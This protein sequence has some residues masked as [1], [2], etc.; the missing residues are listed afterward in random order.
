MTLTD[1]LLAGVITTAIAGAAF[2]TFHSSTDESA[3]KSVAAWNS[4][5]GQA[6][7]TDAS[8]QW[9]FFGGVLQ[10]KRN[11]TTT[12]I[13]PD[14]ALDV[15]TMYS[16][17]N[18]IQ[19]GALPSGFQ[20]SPP[21]GLGAAK[22]V[23]RNQRGMLS[24]VVLTETADVPMVQSSA[25]QSAPQAQAAQGYLTA[26]LSNGTF[27]AQKTTLSGAL[28]DYGITSTPASSTFFPAWY[29]FYRPPVTYPPLNL[30]VGGNYNVTVPNGAHSVTLTLAGAPG[31]IPTIGA[32]LYPLINADNLA[33]WETST[34]EPYPFEYLRW[35]GA[36]ETVPL[37]KAPTSGT[38]N[39]LKSFSF[40][41]SYL[42]FG[43]YTVSC[44]GAFACTRSDGYAV[45]ATNATSSCGTSA[46]S[47]SFNFNDPLYG[48]ANSVSGQFPAAG[49][50][51]TGTVFSSQ[52]QSTSNWSGSTSTVGA[53]TN[54]QSPASVKSIIFPGPYGGDI[55]CTPSTTAGSY[56]CVDLGGGGYASY[57]PFVLSSL[58]CN[59]GASEPSCSYSGYFNAGYPY[60]KPSISGT[61]SPNGANGSYVDPSHLLGYTGKG[62]VYMDIAPLASYQATP[63]PGPTSS[64]VTAT[65]PVVPGENLF[66]H[67]GKYGGQPI[68][69]QSASPYLVTSASPQGGGATMAC[70][71]DCSQQSNV[72]AVSGGGGGGGMLCGTVACST[73]TGDGL[74]TSVSGYSRYSWTQATA[75][76]RIDA[77]FY[78]PGG[79][80]EGYDA[81]AGSFLSQTSNTPA[82]GATSTMGAA[83]ANYVAPIALQQTILPDQGPQA[84]MPQGA[85]NGSGNNCAFSNLSEEANLALGFV[86][87]EA[88][89]C[90]YVSRSGSFSYNGS[91]YPYQ[92]GSS[93]HRFKASDGFA[94]VQ[95]H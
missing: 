37:F 17:P 1:A 21:G 78:G 88:A 68:A 5:V 74:A 27:S 91:V 16:V 57:Y 85:A 9:S 2:V 44:S 33:V 64:V 47:V 48:T 18:L 36:N 65:Y 10:I 38:V 13:A 26:V 62:S 8:T 40:T 4:A 56:S 39:T 3:A 59:G 81:G 87:L 45:T 22:I 86:N 54:S 76:S 42:F 73:Q 32:D 67:V 41:Y 35:D 52:L 84:V 90:A 70:A 30:N 77:L 80:G 95:F 19:D 49:G 55:V 93:S 24:S 69:S 53:V 66:I 58:N 34:A 82:V 14:A 92:F 61:I 28:A 72:L 12:N 15:S 94:I 6:V 43:P 7:L 25:Y 83:G 23:V 29:G 31:G 63:T 75:M 60:G 79:N 20:P 11:G 51:G 89:D 71:G 50:P 46:C